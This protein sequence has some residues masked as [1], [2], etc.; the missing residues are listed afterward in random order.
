MTL[1]RP[2]FSFKVR[3]VRRLN[4]AELSAADVAAGSAL[5]GPLQ[6]MQ[7]RTQFLQG[8]VVREKEAREKG[9]EAASGA[10][11]AGG[12]GKMQTAVNRLMAV[13]RE[14]KQREEAEREKEKEKERERERDQKE[15]KDK[16]GKGGSSM[17]LWRY[18]AAHPLRRCREPAAAEHS[19]AL[20]SNTPA[21]APQQQL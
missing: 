11:A 6:A 3:A 19:F 12:G 17:A 10:G 13:T 20:Q 2:Y 21:S 14:A 7:A 4:G 1:L 5:F 9:K 15:G 18:G 16:D 8:T